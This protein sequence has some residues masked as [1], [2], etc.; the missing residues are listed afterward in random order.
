MSRTLL[1]LKGIPIKEAI[2]SLIAGQDAMAGTALVEFTIFAPM[3]VVMSVYVMDFGLLFFNK[4]EVQNA[5]QAGTQWVIANRIYNQTQIQASAQNATLFTAITV[6]SSQ[7]CGCSEDS[8][9]NAIVAPATP[10]TLTCTSSSSC[11]NGVAGTYVSVTATPTTTYH[12]FIPY[13]LVPSTVD[14]S[15]TAMARIQ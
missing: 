7:F 2:R 15:A 10:A 13:G 1:A 4:I 12:S 14:I 8:S 5:A 11:T 9:G 3:L 6:S